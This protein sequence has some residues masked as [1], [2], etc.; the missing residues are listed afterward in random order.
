MAKKDEAQPR[1]KRVSWMIWGLLAGLVLLFA[2]A[3]SKAWQ[4][5][6]ALKAEL[7]ALQPVA[8]EAAMRR[9]ALQT[10]VAYVQSDEYVEAWSQT[11]AGMTRSGETLILQVSATRTPTPEPPLPALST[12]EPTAMPFLRGLWQSLFGD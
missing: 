5:N 12:P 7:S 11:H 2:S 8:T 9:E 1:S 10:R 4:T 6:Q 3:F